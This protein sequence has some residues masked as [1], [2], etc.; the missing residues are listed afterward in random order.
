MDALRAGGHTVKVFEG[1]I[2]LLKRLSNYIPPDEKTGLPT[3]MIFNMSYGIQGEGR[4]EHVPALLEMAGIPYT[5]PGPR[6]HAVSLD[7]VITKLLLE[8]EGVPTPR[9]KTTRSLNGII[10]GLRFPLVV[11][12]RHESTSNGLALVHDETTLKEAIDLIVNDYKQDALVE[13][14]I[15]GREVAVGLLGN[16]PVEVLPIVEIDFADRPVKMM[17]R[18]DKFHKT[19]DEPGKICPAPLNEALVEKLKRIATTTYSICKIRDY[20]RVD[21]RIDKNGNPFVLEINSM[22]TLGRGG[23]YV[24]SAERAG[25]SFDELICKIVDVAHARYFG[26]P[27]P[28]DTIPIEQPEEA[29]TRSRKAAS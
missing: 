2:K 21:I 1:D 28:R 15:D 17:T 13:E 7:K 20:A 6:S 16:D 27:A 19:E 22:T 8:K 25:Y 23:G 14:Y 4:Y 12:P 11:K 10:N 24:M 9:F 3:G 18:A 26:C 29:E 5:G